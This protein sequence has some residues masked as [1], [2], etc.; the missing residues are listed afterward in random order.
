MSK[1]FWTRI[2]DQM[3][4]EDR[5]EFNQW[6]N[7]LYAFGD[8]VRDRTRVMAHSGSND[9]M[10]HICSMPIFLGEESDSS[11]HPNSKRV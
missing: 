5:I 2:N 1:T 3:T 11:R 9:L 6:R 8:E 4:E 10:N 7:A